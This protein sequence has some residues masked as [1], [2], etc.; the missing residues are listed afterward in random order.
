MSD[1]LIL[2]GVIAFVVTVISLFDMAEHKR[3]KR[4]NSGHE[5]RQ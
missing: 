3:E 1:L 2:V 5:D 4:K